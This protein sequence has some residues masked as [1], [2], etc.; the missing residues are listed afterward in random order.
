MKTLAVNDIRVLVITQYIQTGGL[1]RM[2]VTLSS[3]LS[4]KGVKIFIYIYEYTE[5]A[6]E[7][8]LIDKLSKAG[9]EVITTTKSEGFSLKLAFEIS[10]LIRQK[11]INLIHAHHIGCLIYA[12]IGK[13][14]SLSWPKI[15]ISQH[16]F[17]HLQSNKKYKLY[18]KVF[19]FF[20]DKI[21]AV[22]Q[23]IKDQ[24]LSLSI[25]EEKIKIIENGVNFSSSMVKSIDERNQRRDLLLASLEDESQWKQ[26]DSNKDLFWVLYLARLYPKKGQD[27]AI[28]LWEKLSLEARNSARLIIVGPKTSLSFANHLNGMVEQKGLHNEVL[29]IPG[30][31]EPEKWIAAADLFISCSEYEGMPLGPIEALGSGL[32]G[33]LSRISGHSELIDSANSFPLS[34]QEEGAMLLES[35]F[36]AMKTSYSK[37]RQDSIDKTEKIRKRFSIEKMTNEY[38]EV[39]LEML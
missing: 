39:Y 6:E 21:V 8:S 4:K 17:I 34:K 28:N 36:K 30:T 10:R 27:I 29:F 35:A 25:S 23:A 12:L 20:S 32:P 22:S 31:L 3:A 11:R 26:L 33:I 15:L 24:Y 38:L 9:I 16:S 2:I 1:E 37:T 19:S 13:I 14:I 5:T 18:E 7:D